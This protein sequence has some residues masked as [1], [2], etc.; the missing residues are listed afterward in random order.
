MG[1]RIWHLFNIN[2]NL[3][4]K[5]I[6]WV[7]SAVLIVS[8]IILIPSSATYWNRFENE[9]RNEL[10]HAIKETTH[11]LDLRLSRIEYATQTAAALIGNQILKNQDIDSLMIIA[12]KNIACIDA[13]SIIFDENF[14]ND[15]KLQTDGK[16]YISFAYRN[17]FN[18]RKIDVQEN[19]F[20]NTGNRYWAESYL[21]GTKYW[22][23]PFSLQINNKEHDAIYYSVPLSSA[24]GKRFAVFCSIVWLE[25]M[26]DIVLKNKARKDIDVSIYADNGKCIVAPDDY[27]LKLKP[28]ELI[29]EKRNIN[30]LGWTIVFSA[31]RNIVITKVERA[32]LHY[33]INVLILILTM[34]IAIILSIRYV[35]R[36]FVKEQRKTAEIKAAMQHELNLAAKAQQELI[37]H[38]FPPFP[39]RKEISIFACLHPARDVG[40]DLYDYFISND[41]LYFCIGDVSGKG[42]PASL[43]MTAT[44][45]LFRT[46][47]NEY[48]TTSEAVSQMNKALCIDNEQC[49]FV[50][51]FFGK[52]N[53]KNGDLEY[54]NAGHNSPILNQSYLPFAKGM[55]LGVLEDAEY[56]TEHI[57]MNEDDV[58][59]LYTDGITEAKNCENRNLGEEEVLRIAQVNMAADGKQYL[60]AMLSQ[61][62]QHAGNEPQSDD[63]TMLYIKRKQ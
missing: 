1:I 30:R 23:A 47:A 15:A 9:Q 26:N 28:K 42:V 7:V 58:L 56:E 16:R 20:E 27:I 60:D 19:I 43:F 49:M 57:K 41:Y 6:L 25:W 37:P 18:T 55:P 46:V 22:G 45:Y 53:L 59:F 8:V 52:L 4:S 11:A 36:P 34:V 17:N 31:D 33:V 3:E 21:H 48:V 32:I 51:F 50:T 13:A 38:K 62:H 29:V 63:I 10:E 39:D 35:A 40:G 54:C 12:I 24:N 61:I 44:H 2:K 5:L 14:V